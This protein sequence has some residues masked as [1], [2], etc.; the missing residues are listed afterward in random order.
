MRLE[1]RSP[2]ELAENPLNWR[3]HP[4]SQLAALADVLTE[5]GWAGAC[6][7]NEAT[8]RL[9]DGHARRQVAAAQ[10]AERVPVLVGSWTE[11]Q[12]RKILATLDPLAAMA[13]ADRTALDALLREVQTGSE[14]VAGLLTELAQANGI[15]P[16][17]PGGPA[18][19]DRGPQTE[20]A[21]ELQA[22]WGTEPGQLWLVPSKSTPG[23]AHRLL[24]GDSTKVADVARLMDGKRAVLMP[25]DPPYL[26]DYQGGNHPQSWSNKPEVKDKHWDDYQEGEG[27]EF[28][29]RFLQVA[30]EQALVANPAVYQ[31]HAHRRQALVEQAWV[32][33]GLLVHQQIIWVKSRAVLTRSHYMWQHEPCFYGWPQGHQ[34]QRKPPSNASTVWEIDQQGL[35]GIHPTEKPVQIMARPI[36]YHTQ[37]GELCYEPFSGSGTCLVAAEQ[38]GRVCYALEKAPAFVAAAL[39]RLANLGLAPEVLP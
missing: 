17:L 24:C 1:W 20:R 31:W 2:A 14:A 29:T 32:E 15:V 9:I 33:N 4:E 19:P 16:A 23:Q 25:T 22:K 38:L 18:A 21:A 10:G 12:E 26:V 7:Y 3:R 36:E 27:S 34:P 13:E 5:V 8:G 6:L 37:P 28:F 30:L 35:E 39:E 11:E